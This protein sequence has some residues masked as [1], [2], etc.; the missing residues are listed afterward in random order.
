[1][2]LI[3]LIFVLFVSEAVQA[4]DWIGAAAALS[5][6]AS[7]E[8]LDQNTLD[9]Y[10][11]LHLHR[12][13]ING[14]RITSLLTPYQVATVQDYRRRCGDI[15]SPA[16]LALV[17]GFSPE[18]VR[19][20]EPFIT[21]ESSH[22][23]GEAVQDTLRI[24]IKA[25]LR[26]D[27]NSV[28][29]KLLADGGDAAQAGFARRYYYDGRSG[30]SFFAS[31]GFP[32]GRFLAGCFNLRY[33]EGLLFW[34]GLSMDQTST[35][36]GFSRRGAGLSPSLS[37]SGEGTQRGFAGEYSRGIWNGMAFISENAVGGHISA[38]SLSGSYGL[39]FKYEN[40]LNA[41]ADIR[42][43]LWGADFFGEAAI[44]PGAWAAVGGARVPFSDALSGAIRLEASP[45]AWTGRKYG[46]YSAALGLKYLGGG[47]VSIAGKT[48]FG[49]SEKRH[50][51]DAVAKLRLLPIPFADPCRRELKFTVSWGFRPDSLLR[52]DTRA[53]ARF[54]S[55]EPTRAELR[56]DML[57][58]DGRVSVK[59]RIHGSWCEGPG[60]LSYGELGYA[61]GEFQI[62]FRSMAYYTS[63]WA[64]R[65]YVYERDVP[66]S[67]SVPACYGS[68]RSVS[69]MASHTL[70][71]RRFRMKN[72]LRAF[73]TEQKKS[74]TK[75]GLKFQTTIEF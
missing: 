6:C 45:S 25:I 22:R 16:E 55:Y 14:G 53:I 65:I 75:A 49:S 48:G 5:G 37:W 23:P 64:S 73:V 38:L 18:K 58:S 34:S 44:R 62:W 41:S 3:I 20:L 63:S 46:E 29:G 51:I 12:V 8:E 1:M 19:A 40:G 59:L 31:C 35:I 21:F 4:Q 56:S 10:E 30:G 13:R 60:V 9:H 72:A 39:G 74:G 33:G 32:G 71:L 2:R 15:L 69:I 11:Y 27:M 68:G 61:P 43:H 24:R 57:L 42:Q 52:L 17:D 50:S 66:G 67:F 47:Y 54:R 70:T 26:A 28:A 7:A 36:D